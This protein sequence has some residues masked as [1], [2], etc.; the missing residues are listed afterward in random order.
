MMHKLITHGTITLIGLSC[1]LLTGCPGNP[2]AIDPPPE[3][4]KFFLEEFF[5]STSADIELVLLGDTI[6]IE[7]NDSIAHS[8]FATTTLMDNKI[9]LD[10]W[11]TG[12][13]ETQNN[14]ISLLMDGQLKKNWK[15][16]MESQGLMINSPFNYDSWIITS[17]NPDANNVVG[18][19]TFT[20][21]DDDL[22]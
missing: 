20:I 17:W 8:E 6:A 18:K 1:I 14:S 19:I 4:S 16:I 2:F 12:Y 22:N 15:G 9:I 3:E 21:T 13:S 10:D 11:F 5:N 7:S